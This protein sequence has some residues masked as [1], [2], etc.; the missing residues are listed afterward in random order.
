MYVHN[1]LCAF[2][3]CTGPA[4]APLVAVRPGGL[5]TITVDIT[6]PVYGRECVD[7]YRGNAV[8]GERILT[9]NRTVTDPNQALYTIVFPGVDLCGDIL[10]NVTAVGVTDGRE[11]TSSTPFTMDVFNRSSE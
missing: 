1:V 7:Y 5:S 11:G 3:T 8:V 9:R 10:N 4:A 2:H 6:A